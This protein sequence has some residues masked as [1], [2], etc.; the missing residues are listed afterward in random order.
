M[1]VVRA[2]LPMAIDRT[3]RRLSRH[4]RIVLTRLIDA[5]T[6]RDDRQVDAN[7]LRDALRVRDKIAVF[8]P[9]THNRPGKSRTTRGA[10]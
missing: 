5:A 2:E 10:R 9:R 8:V 6:G 1:A 3:S 7:L 4:E